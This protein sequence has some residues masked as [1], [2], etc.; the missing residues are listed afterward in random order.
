M[1][2]GDQVYG[3]VTPAEAS[4]I[5]DK[6]LKGEKAKTA[7]KAEPAAAAAPVS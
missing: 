1:M 2:V 7:P 4:R 6:V 5:L 3:P